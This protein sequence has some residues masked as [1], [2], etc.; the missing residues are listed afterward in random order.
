MT[1]VTHPLDLVTEEEI[2]VAAALVRADARFPE[3]AV[4]V[5]LRLHEP[6]KDV[7][8]GFEPGAPIDREIEAV[9]VPPGELI[10]YEV[11]VSVTKGAIRE[12]T[13][14]EG[15][16]PALMFGESMQAIKALRADPVWQA[17]M[18]KRGIEDFD[19]VQIDPWPAGSFDSP[20]EEGRRISRCISYLR[21]SNTDNGY[22]RP[23]EGV[24]AFVDGGRH[25]VL[26]VLDLGVVPLP[27]ERAAYL[28]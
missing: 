11:V 26:E 27:P 18:R 8:L 13:P 15:M 10:A 9:V 20:H 22:A 23:I 5:H 28:A 4:F 2:A 17:A 24:L 6:H 21:E 1:S 25:E 12:W 19:L 16:R 14:H 3:D 7:V